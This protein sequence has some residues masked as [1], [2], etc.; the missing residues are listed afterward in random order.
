MG[1]VSSRRN[2]THS[3]LTVRLPCLLLLSSRWGEAGYIRL[4]R[5]QNMCGV[6][7]EAVYPL[8][9]RPV[10]PAPA[11]GPRPP[12][13]APPGPTPPPPGPTP[14]PPGPTPPPI[15]PTPPAP[16][17]PTPPPTPPTPPPAPGAY[18]YGN[19]FNGACKAGEQNV[20]FPGVLSGAICAATCTHILHSGCP[21][22]TPPGISARPACSYRDG[23]IKYCMLECDGSATG[24][25]GNASAG[26]VGAE[27]GECG[28][29]ASCKQLTPT[30]QIFICTYDHILS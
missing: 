1:Q 3:Q 9:V 18:H 12:T 11:P 5:G 24:A 23:N 15:L 16:P 20:S 6:A 27:D 19:P 14:P 7:E 25:G 29:G 4:A 13:P 21:T 10:G 22:D 28:V 17:P 30:A 26:A 2:C 8:N